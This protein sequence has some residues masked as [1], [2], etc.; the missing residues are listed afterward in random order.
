MTF[1]D[2]LNQSEAQCVAWN[3][4]LAHAEKVSSAVISNMINQFST[5]LQINE[6]E[7]HAAD[8]LRLYKLLSKVTHLKKKSYVKNFWV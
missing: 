7:E 5:H 1:E 3:S 8:E 4:T 2:V 6:T